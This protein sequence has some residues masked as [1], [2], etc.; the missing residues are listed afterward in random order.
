MGKYNQSIFPNSEP[1]SYEE[2]II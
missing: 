2:T 1:D